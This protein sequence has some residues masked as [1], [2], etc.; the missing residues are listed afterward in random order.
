M[1]CSSKSAST[2]TMAILCSWMASYLI[3]SSLNMSYLLSL[4]AS[5]WLNEERKV[6]ISMAMVGSEKI[7]SFMMGEVKPTASGVSKG[8]NL[9]A[10]RDSA[11]RIERSSG[12]EDY[13]QIDTGGQVVEGEY[14]SIMNP[15]KTFF[16]VWK[17]G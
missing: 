14:S 2:A 7:A 9:E 11:W 1:S 4:A 12:R 17:T 5:E 16:E 15:H 10:T 3:S 8:G 13:R 6:A